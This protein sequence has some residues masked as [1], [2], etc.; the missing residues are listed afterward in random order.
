MKKRRTQTTGGSL[1]KDGRGDGA[2]GHSNF[3]IT[4]PVR[5]HPSLF[6]D[7][8]G[9]SSDDDEQQLGTVVAKANPKAAPKAAIKPKASKP[10]PAARREELPPR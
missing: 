2:I 3:P 8:G 6:D 4:P 5:H 7:E 9:G 1:G 10:E